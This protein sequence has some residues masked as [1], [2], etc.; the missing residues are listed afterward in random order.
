MRD[1]DGEIIHKIKRNR[2]LGLGSLAPRL[3]KAIPCLGPGREMLCACGCGEKIIERPHHKRYGTPLFVWGHNSKG[4][5]N[6]FYG[7]THT[8]VVKTE[9]RRRMK[10]RKRDPLSLETKIKI[11]NANRG[12]KYTEESRKKISEAGRER[13]ISDKTRKKMADS[14]RGNKSSFWKGGVDKKIYK[15]Y[16]N[17][18]YRLWRERVFKRDNYTCQKCKQRG[19]FLHP[20]HIKSYTHFP[21]LRYEISNGI[22]LHKKCHNNLHWFKKTKEGVKFRES[23]T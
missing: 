3:T 7:K 11:G 17:L 18:D 22:T 2:A 14:H 12:R 19:D 4:G 10:D 6:P 23:D 20:H 21:E 13:I 1:W 16:N 15:H 9:Q 5:N 8:T